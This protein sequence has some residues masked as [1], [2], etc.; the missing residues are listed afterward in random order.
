MLKTK[1]ATAHGMLLALCLLTCSRVTRAAS[2]V[3]PHA[4]PT[5][6]F[7]ATALRGSA[8][9]GPVKVLGKTSTR[10]KR[11]TFENGILSIRGGDRGTKSQL[12]LSPISFDNAPFCQFNK[13]I[14][15]VN[16]LGFVI[17][18]ISGG[19]HLHLDLL[20]TGAFAMAAIPTGLASAIP[21]VQLSA[22]CVSLW[23]TK[24]ASFLFFRAIKMKHDSRLTDTLST[25][26]G[27]F[28]FWFISLLWGCM[29][30]LPHSLGATSSYNTPLLQSPCSIAGG[31]L[32][33][34]G[35]LT[36][37]TADVQKW[38]FKQSNPKQFCN[39]GV[40]SMSQHP[41]FLGNLLLWSGIFLMNAP[42]L[43][44]PPPAVTAETALTAIF[45]TLWRFK[46]VALA[47]LSPLFMYTLFSGQASG[48]I[49]NA[50]E[51][52]QKKYGGDSNFVNYVETVPLIFPNPFKMLSGS[53]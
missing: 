22:A 18:L 16:A 13:I 50:K 9:I 20:G 35:F 29:C 15:V 45:Q 49:T 43:V 4:P 32:F 2:F 5:S 24:L 37:T 6:V 23:S 26:S 46:R 53:K 51:L 40:W 28:G 21:R 31:A 41:N 12:R 44:D 48:T 39:V 34:I 47:A 25:T 42:A 1:R 10:F 52:A 3:S 38:L 33:A 14:I 27:T 11:N 19:S 8:L 36:E 17:S 7:L 30:S